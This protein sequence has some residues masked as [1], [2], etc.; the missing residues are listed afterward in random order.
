MKT[1]PEGRSPRELEDFVKQ[2]PRG[3]ACHSWDA[4]CTGTSNRKKALM[5]SLYERQKGICAYCEI[6]L[7]SPDEDL[8]EGKRDLQVE[9][10]HP[11]RD[12]ETSPSQDCCWGLYWPNLFAACLG[13]T[14]ADVRNPCH[15]CASTPGE[16]NHHCGESNGKGGDILDGT[17]LNPHDI[18]AKSR[19]FTFWYADGSRDRIYLKP[20]EE[21][22][23]AAGVQA[24]LVQ[25][26]IERL[27]LNCRLLAKLRGGAKA[28]VEKRIKKF[29]Q[30]GVGDQE[31][32]KRAVRMAF[33]TEDGLW[34]EFFTTLRALYPTAAEDY[35]KSQ[36]YQ[37]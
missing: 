36:D 4:F 19:L 28:A 16:D 20:Y 1:I 31:A 37:G 5:R 32:I 3:D 23:R 11:K 15:Y 10:F 24:E 8:D 25:N 17:I 34:P 14:Q 18:D 13:G 21:G 27:N 2:H 6:R 30:S 9:H 12:D 29:K 35:L 26:T 22:C 33:S 7:D